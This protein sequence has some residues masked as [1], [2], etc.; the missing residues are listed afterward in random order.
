MKIVIG[1]LYPELMSIYGDRGNIIALTR[2]AEWAGLEVEVRPV[3]LGEAA[4]LTDLD[5]AFIGGGQDR[6]QALIADDLSKIKAPSLRAAVQ[7]GLALLAVCGGFQLLGHYF[8]N[9]SG[10]TLP[11]VGIFDAWT[12]AGRKRRIGDVIARCDD[13]GRPRTLVG[14]ENHSG[15][16][17]LGQGTRPLGRVLFGYGNNGEDRLEGA[18]YRN[19]FGTYLHGS[20]LPKNPWLADRLIRSAIE[21]RYGRADA[22]EPVDDALENLAHE[23]V[24]AR[25]QKRGKLDSGAI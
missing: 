7:D 20:L 9:G 13:D 10:T 17:Y 21:R 2:R 19:A 4:D 3:G 16:T 11:G 1:H 8:R 18:R 12:I 22:L 15:K 14:F 23:A 6:E 25:I 24:I 5:I